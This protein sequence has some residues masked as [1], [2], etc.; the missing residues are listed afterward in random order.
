MSQSPDPEDGAQRSVAELLARHGGSSPSGGGRRRRAPD[1][2]ETPSNSTASNPTASNSTAEP[3]RPSRSG[4]YR[5]SLTSYR[6]AGS[7]AGR[8]PAAAA[9]GRTEDEEATRFGP[10]PLGNGDLF[11]ARGGDNGSHTE[12]LPRAEPGPAV[13]PSPAPVPPRPPARP[14]G[15]H[16]GEPPAG[17]NWS[18][19]EGDPPAV[20]G[21]EAQRLRIVPSIEDEFPGA[22]P[23]ETGPSAADAEDNW[24]TRSVEEASPVR[25]WAVVA[26]QVGGGVVGGAVLWLACEWLWQSI[27]VLALI[28]A[29]AVITGLVWVVRRVRR[30]EDLQTT[31]IAV[32]VG[33]FVTVSPAA[34]L[35]V[36]R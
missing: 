6:S 2:A 30:A 22:Q 35:L 28:V 16:R 11:T 12:Q 19:A 1:P 17:L 21:T 25:E 24:H 10:P 36:G 7:D 23:E 20:G 8:D 33:L 26:G 34:L 27:P 3:F 31:V 14:R 4:Q 18:P 15:P 9:P 32:L 5:S 29:L 13:S